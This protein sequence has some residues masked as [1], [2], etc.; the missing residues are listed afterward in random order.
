MTTSK[1][2]ATD[3]IQLAREKNVEMVDL[4]FI[5]VPST[6]QHLSIPVSELTSELF[7]EGT[8]FDGSSIRGFQTID[9]SDMLLVPDPS[10]A[11]TNPD[12]D[13]TT[14]SLICN[15][16]DPQT[17]GNYSRDLRWVAQK[18]EAYLKSSGIGDIS[19][20]GPELEFF[21]FDSARFDQNARSGYYFMDSDEGVWNSGSE[22][23]L[24]GD[25]NRAFRPRHKEGYFPAPPTAIN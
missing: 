5:D 19:Y 15:V 12:Y 22:L 20:W 16:R 4:K 11:A 23:S 6:L 18:A 21:I 13:I 10:T 3:V 2:T 14:L 25:L 24:S 7:E 1:L 17:D 9:E 8:G